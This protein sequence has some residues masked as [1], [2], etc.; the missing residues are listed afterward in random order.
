M[1]T[2]ANI[3]EDGEIRVMMIGHCRRRLLNVEGWKIE[4]GKAELTEERV[5]PSGSASVTHRQNDKVAQFVQRKF[6]ITN[7]SA[8]LPDQLAGYVLTFLAVT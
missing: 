8:I 7:F 4:T 1:I 2:L 6:W 5:N 3:N